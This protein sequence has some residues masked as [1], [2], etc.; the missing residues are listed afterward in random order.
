MQEVFRAIGRLAKSNIN[1]MI[2]GQSGTGKELVANALHQHSPRSANP[3]VAINIAAIPAELLESELF[4]HE[5]GAFTGAQAQRKGRFEQANGGTLFLDEIGEMSA[6]LQTRLLRVLSDRRFYRVGGRDLVSVDVRV[7]AATN[8]D[9]EKQVEAGEFREDL[10]HRLNV[11]RID[12][13]SLQERAE[14]VPLLAKRFLRVS[15][16]ELEVEIKQLSEPALAKMMAYDWPGNVRQLENMC[17]WITVMAPATI[18][19]VE[20]LPKELS[21]VVEDSISYDWEASLTKLVRNQLAMGKQDILDE[22][23]KRFEA[24]MLKVALDHTGGHRQNAAKVLGWGRNTL[25]RKL[26]DLDIS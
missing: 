26:K 9:L 1:V 19:S 25:T 12:I 14:D 17:R 13:P 7:L 24:V 15:A 22:L 23:L 16:D 6:D 18:V 10:Y 4:G 20:D 11:I 3:F 8:R 2:C 5:K 21:Q